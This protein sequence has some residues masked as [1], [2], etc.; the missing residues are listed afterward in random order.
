[1]CPPPPPPLLK[2]LVGVSPRPPLPTL[3]DKA[4]KGDGWIRLSSAVPKIQWDSKTHCPYG[5]Y[6]MGNL[7]LSYSFFKRFPLE[8][9]L[10]Y[11]N[12]L[13]LSH[14][15]PICRNVVFITGI[16]RQHPCQERKQAPNQVVIPA[17]L[18]K[19]PRSFPWQIGG[20]EKYD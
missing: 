8:L 1:M 7:Y 13:V 14:Y 16:S 17:Q 9:F 4:A 6:A 5:Y 15:R 2:L 19:L 3:M 11:S 20:T 18:F 10:E 12:F